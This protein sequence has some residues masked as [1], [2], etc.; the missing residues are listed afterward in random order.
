MDA[1]NL[2][3]RRPGAFTSLIFPAYNP[4]P[5]LE[6]TWRELMQFLQRAPGEWEVLF[7]CDGCTDGTPARLTEWARAEGGRIRIVSYAPNHGKGYAV[8]RGLEVACGEWR[9]FTD[10]DLAYRFDDVL[11]VVQALQAGASVAIASRTHSESLLVL[12]AR[13]QGYAYRRHLQS[14]AFSAL[15]RL[16]L[17]LKQRDT[18]AGLK[19]LSAAAAQTILPRLSCDGFGFDC[20]LLTACQHYGLTVAEVPVCVRYENRASTTGF[21][22][23]RAMVKEL[24]TIRRTWRQM[25]PPE[26]AHTTEP[27]RQAA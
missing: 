8:R 22:A 2:D 25:A 4:G 24:W 10:V 9:L 18:Q 23:M 11:R 14:L 17:P 1:R 21:G 20:E 12:P 19:G 7:V 27:N 6:R 26:P 3:T 13:L 15:V 5:I 16:L